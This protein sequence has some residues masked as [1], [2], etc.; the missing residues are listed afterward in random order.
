MALRSHVVFKTQTATTILHLNQQKNDLKAVT[1]YSYCCL[2][3]YNTPVHECRYFSCLLGS[4]MQHILRSQRF[5]VVAD[6]EDRDL[7]AT[8]LQPSSVLQSSVFLT[9]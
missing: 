4:D 6:R 3:L 2:P 1:A 9:V 7:K 8:A 5:K